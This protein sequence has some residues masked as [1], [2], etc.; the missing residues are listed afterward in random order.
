[1]VIFKSPK[2]RVVGLRQKMDS[3]W[4]ING[5]WSY[6]HVSVTRPGSPIL[7]VLKDGGKER[8]L[9]ILHVVVQSTKFLG[10][11][12]CSS[13]I[14]FV[15]VFF[16][17][18]IAINGVITLSWPDKLWLVFFHPITTRKIHHHFSPPLW[19][20]ICFLG[21]LFQA[22][23]KQIQDIETKAKTGWNSRFHF[24]VPSSIP[25]VYWS[26]HPILATW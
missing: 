17:G 8:I 10:I 22:A 13:W 12:L 6:P 19:G 20:E 18:T 15:G 14:W 4:L 5:G 21:T 11:V 7:Q 9:Q 2:D 25:S 26:V 1:M 3:F 24:L 16:R 23:M